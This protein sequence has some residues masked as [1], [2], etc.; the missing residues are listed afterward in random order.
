MRI[1]LSGK[2]CERREEEGKRP[3]AAPVCSVR[4]LLVFEEGIRSLERLNDDGALTA[5]RPIVRKMI[6]VTDLCT[7]MSA[8]AILRILC[9]GDTGGVNMSFVIVRHMRKGF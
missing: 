2:K 5:G 4:D 3:G 9:S 1:G 6:A 7:T 8:S